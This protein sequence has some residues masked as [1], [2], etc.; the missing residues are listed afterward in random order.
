DD[1]VL[2]RS[3]EI[4]DRPAAARA[5]RVLRLRERE[6]LLVRLH[7]EEEDVAARLVRPRAAREVAGADVV[8]DEV[9]RPDVEILQIERVASADRRALLRD[10][11]RDDLVA[12]A[13]HGVDEVE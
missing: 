10:V 1:D 12:V 7:L 6:L 2:L 11:E 3:D 8:G 5:R 9:A 4:V 13:A